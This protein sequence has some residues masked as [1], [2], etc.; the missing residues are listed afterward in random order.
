[1]ISTIITITTTVA[2]QAYAAVSVQLESL[3]SC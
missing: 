3:V 2:C 1:M